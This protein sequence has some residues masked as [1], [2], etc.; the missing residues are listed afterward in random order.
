[1]RLV[2]TVWALADRHEIF[3]RIEIDNP[4]AAVT[5]DERIEA[6]AQRL[7]RFPNSGRP[8]RV[9]GTREL[10]VTRTRFVA[11][12]V[13]T[14]DSSFVWSPPGSGLTTD[15]EAT[16]AKLFARFV[17]KYDA[18][19]EIVDVNDAETL[20]DGISEEPRAAQEAEG[21]ELP[22]LLVEAVSAYRASHGLI[23]T[24]PVVTP[25][26]PFRVTRVRSCARA[27]AA[28]SV[29][30]TG[31]LRSAVSSPHLRAAAVSTDTMR[32]AKSL[33]IWSTHVDKASAMIGSTRRLVA[34]P[35][36]NSPK[37][38]T[39]RNSRRP[40]TPSRNAVTA[41]FGRVFRVSEM[42]LVARR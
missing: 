18:S 36:R 41:A 32:S 28:M 7:T 23:T 27:L 17:S 3:S 19:A 42:T 11:A 8:G 40:S 30:T 39:L 20:V 5:V 13:A 29:S 38:S 6:S 1:V 2:W 26:R 37:V 22:V 24:T 10:V 31:R 35:L 15:P 12:Y 14:D 21:P 4:R 25:S 33:S 34:T 16:L 9:E